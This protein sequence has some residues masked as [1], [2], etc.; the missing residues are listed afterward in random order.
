MNRSELEQLVNL[1]T[2]QVL[3]SM[4]QG[5]ACAESCAATQG[6]PNVLVIGGGTQ[7][8]QEL[9]HS[10]VLFDPEDYKSHRNILRYDRVVITALTFAQLADIALGRAEDA[11]SC[12]VVHALLEGVDVFLL[13]NALPF[14]AYAG[15]GST[16]LYHL[17]EGY[18]QTL[19][20]FG[21]KLY[22]HKTAPDLPEPKPPKYQAPPVAV[23]V[24]TAVPNASRLVTEAA[25]LAMVKQGSPL[26]LPSASIITPSAR[27]VFAQAGITLILEDT[28]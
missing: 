11:A 5:T 25:A 18:A 3:S 24:G 14:R 12:A 1:V 20:I 26:R 7:L 19:Q 23:P 15:K 27:D 22:R 21:V 28:Q 16:A 17:L 9:C 4:Q 13:E 8:P 10:C 6:L 2:Q